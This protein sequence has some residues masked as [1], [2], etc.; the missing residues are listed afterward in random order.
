MSANGDIVANGAGVAIDKPE[1]TGAYTESSSSLPTSLPLT[2]CIDRFDGVCGTATATIAC[3]TE[4]IWDGSTWSKGTP[5]IFQHV[6]LNANYNTQTHGNINACQ[7]TV[8]LE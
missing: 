6:I 2:T 3:V 7:M 4:N 5:T 1:M 8:K